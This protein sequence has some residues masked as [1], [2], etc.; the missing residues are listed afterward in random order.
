M[1]GK[2]NALPALARVATMA[3]A[4]TVALATPGPAQ[5]GGTSPSGAGELQ[6][7]SAPTLR[8]ASAIGALPPSSTVQAEVILAPR[9]PAALEQFA[10]DV[11]TPGSGEFHHYLA[12]GEFGRDFG[13]TPTTVR[14][15]DA[16]LLASGLQPGTASANGLSIP[17]T[18]TA[19]RAESGFHVALESV[20]LS[21]GRVGF[22]NTAAPRLPATVAGAVSAVLGLSDLDAAQPMGLVPLAHATLSPRK[23]GVEARASAA[24]S[25]P[26][27][28]CQD[29]TNEAAALPGVRGYTSDEIALAYGAD[30]LYYEGD[31][32][33]GAYDPPAPV[34]VAIFEG[35]TDDTLASDVAAFE[36][37]YGATGKVTTDKVDGGA[38][39]NSSDPGLET[40]LDVD[41]VLGLA[42]QASVIVYQG[43]PDDAGTYSI[44]QTI[45]AD[46]TAQVVSMSWGSCDLPDDPSHVTDMQA[47]YPLF[48]QAVTQGQ[49]VVASTGDSGSE[50]C[51]YDPDGSGSA[52]ALA[53]DDPASQPL[54]TGVGGTKL[55][56]GAP[57]DETAWTGGGGGVSHLW[58]MPSYQ[59]SSAVGGIREPGLSDGA[60]C[61]APAGTDCREVPDVSADASPS[62]PY[63]VYWNGG[64]TLVGGTSGST[65]TWAGLTAL[66]DATPAC[67]TTGPVG[68]LNPS[69]Y[70]IAGGAHAADALNDV[71]AGNNDFTGG[72]GGDYPS[73]SGYDMAT[74]L[75]TPDVGAEGGDG[76]RRA[77]V[78]A[79][80]P[81]GHE[82][83][84]LH[85]RRGGGSGDHD[86]RH[87]LHARHH[88]QLRRNPGGVGLGAELHDRQGGDPG[89]VRDGV[90][91]RHD[92]RGQRLRHVHL[93]ERDVVEHDEHD[94]R[95]RLDVDHHHHDHHV[96]GDDSQRHGHDQRH[97]HADQP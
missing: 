50:D 20:R 88:G 72:H 9:D 56:L 30:F 60:P 39:E 61:G 73:G 41:N 44:L 34:T 10:I 37:C 3:L 67:A 15:V 21:S 47:E 71:T 66:I 76:L 28:P 2:H 97:R 54:V 18:T 69:L 91:D 96:D 36:Q 89:R 87:R 4:M 62:T 58:T 27:A 42:P 80:D 46:D 33:A 92:G 14:T 23:V 93:H 86:R 6:I 5:A 52:G 75:G 24:A 48:M 59:S 78:P 70:R 38:P 81:C 53:V 8:G 85:R 51:D 43:P 65:P 25:A 11:S 57:P 95:L 79:P 82:R 77:A 49:T 26:P 64:W 84:P 68:F 29:A 35:E 32:G 12:P 94:V 7:G 55:E 17:V 16:A 83:H 22:T 40:D 74:G 31:Y 1:L 45:M 63:V 90:A 13:A 19:G